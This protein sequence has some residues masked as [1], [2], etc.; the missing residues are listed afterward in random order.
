MIRL[1]VGMSLNTGQL[2]TFP[3]GF[4]N[5]AKIRIFFP[6]YSESYE[7]TS[8]DNFRNHHFSLKETQSEIIWLAHSKKK[9]IGGENPTF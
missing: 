7:D 2:E 9:M 1:V 6:I 4:F 8:T 5:R 3:Q